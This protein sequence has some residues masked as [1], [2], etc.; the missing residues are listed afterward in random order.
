M[1]D[2]RMK[3]SIAAA[4]GAMLGGAFLLLTGGDPRKPRISRARAGR[5][6]PRP[7]N[8]PVRPAGTQQMRNP[9][10]DW[11]RVDESSDQSFPASDP[12][13]NY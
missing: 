13:S 9:P 4:A 6:A 8:A 11:D 3:R 2:D 5:P 7:P 10:K 1:E 12:P